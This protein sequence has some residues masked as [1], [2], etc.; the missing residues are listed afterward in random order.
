ML[1]S[2]YKDLIVKFNRNP[3]HFFEL[4][5]PTHQAEGYNRVCG[6]QV[7]VFLEISGDNFKELSFTGDCCA[8][9]KASA[10]M[11][12][13]HLEGKTKEEFKIY[14]DNF[15]ALIHGNREDHTVKDF[16][17]FKEL[18]DMPSRIPCATLAWGALEA[19]LNGQTNST[20]EK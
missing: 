6:D 12:I 19:A 5:H 4:A 18:R 20:T 1:N 13:H 9:A 10:S 7:R 2:A 16:E 17:I 15:C 3:H 8:V 14:F 11:M